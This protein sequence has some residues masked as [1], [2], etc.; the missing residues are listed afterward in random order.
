MGSREDAGD[1]VV[2]EDLEGGTANLIASIIEEED[3][4]LPPVRTFLVQLLDE[5]ENEEL[6]NLIIRVALE[7]G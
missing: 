3:C 1:A 4:I 7:A 2:G 6:H 5:I